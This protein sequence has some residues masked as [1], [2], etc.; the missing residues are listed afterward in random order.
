[1]RL[2]D[3]FDPKNIISDC[4]F[5]A[6]GLSN[7]NTG[8]RTLSFLD[9]TKFIDELKNNENICALICNQS[10]ISGI[11]LGLFEGIVVSDTPRKEYFQLHNTLCSTANYTGNMPTSHIG[12]NCKI[13]PLSRIDDKG[14]FIGDNVVIGDFVS[15]QGPCSIGNNTIISSGA[16]IG[17]SGFEFKRFESDVLDV[18]HCGSVEIGENVKIWENVSIHKAV[19][20]WDKTLVDSWSRIGAQ[21]HIDHGA[22]VGEFV[23]ICARCIISGRVSL[24]NHAF[25]GPGSI[26]SNRIEIGNYAKVL[27]GSVVT[28]DVPQCSIVSGN[29]AIE[30][31]KHMFRVKADSS[32]VFR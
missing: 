24:G 6:L 15:I 13:S 14:V 17:G 5:E 10:D 19:Y 4:E 1:M 9:D 29:F 26:I 2:S 7:S 16:S 21:T 30:H 32:I 12:N 28:Q 20:P 23:E 31:E 22:K 18:V 11:P 27:I 3:Y 25:V 8:A